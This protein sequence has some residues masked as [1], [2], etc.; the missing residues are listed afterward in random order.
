MDRG[1]WWAT[2]QGVIQALDMTWWLN[3]SNFNYWDSLG[4]DMRMIRANWHFI[5]FIIF[6]L[7]IGS[8]PPWLPAVPGTGHIHPLPLGRLCA[9][10]F[11][12]DKGGWMTLLSG[13]LRYFT[14]PGLHWPDWL[15]MCQGMTKVAVYGVCTSTGPKERG[16]DPAVCNA[17][18]HSQPA[19]EGPTGAKAPLLQPSREGAAARGKP[20]KTKQ[21]KTGKLARHK[22]CCHSLSMPASPPTPKDPGAP[23][24]GK[25]LNF[26]FG[27]PRLQVHSRIEILA[28][29]TTWIQAMWQLGSFFKLFLFKLEDNWFTVAC[30]F[31]P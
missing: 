24:T 12:S 27:A 18:Q 31:L 1:V 30:W 16:G 28:E 8:V 22:P 9:E 15:G 10:V 19:A 5:G 29:I 7:S 14:R 13:M 23:L 11:I 20:R 26:S 17:R 4:Q 6:R 2:V 3:N 21:I 25:W